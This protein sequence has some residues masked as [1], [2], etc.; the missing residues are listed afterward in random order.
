MSNEFMIQ[1]AKTSLFLVKGNQKSHV[2]VTTPE[3]VTLMQNATSPFLW[4][5]H[6]STYIK[7]Y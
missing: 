4:Y 5:T 7:N 1:N 2:V 6:W 3:S